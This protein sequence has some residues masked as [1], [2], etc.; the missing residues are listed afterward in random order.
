MRYLAIILCT[1]FSVGAFGQGKTPFG[2]SRAQ[3][4]SITG[5]QIRATAYGI[6]NDTA[7]AIFLPG[8]IVKQISISRFNGSGGITDTT[9]L[10]NRINGKLDSIKISNDTL[11]SYKNGA[12]TFVGIITGGSSTY[13][14]GYGLN[15]AGNRFDVDTSVIPDYRIL[16][17]VINDS[18][19]LLRTYIATN[20]YDKTQVDS[21]SAGKSDTAHGHTF[22]EVTEA[23]NTTTYP[24]TVLDVNFDT[25]P[26]YSAARAAARMYAG[27]DSVKVG[28]CIVKFAVDGGG[29][30]TPSLLANADHRGIRFTSLSYGSGPILT[31]N[32]APT[33]TK[34]LYCSVTPDETWANYG[35][36][37][38][39]RANLGNLQIEM[40]WPKG[41]WAGLMFRDSTNTWRFS[42]NIQ[43]SAVTETG[44]NTIA[45]EETSSGQMG[46]KINAISD[47]QGMVSSG[48]EIIYAGPNGYRVVKSQNYP[49]YLQKQFNIVDAYGNPVPFSALTHLDMFMVNS[50]RSFQMNPQWNYNIWNLFSSSCNLWVT[51]VYEYINMWFLLLGVPFRIRR[52]KRGFKVELIKM[53]RA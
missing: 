35:V 22:Q 36:T 14:D 25:I 24:I 6:I 3:D 34:I 33:A 18:N 49:Y 17:E 32:F 7:I 1:L 47:Y 8:G 37:A 39:A 45:W 16:D 12:G 28:F 29:N 46:G 11:Y 10:S 5:G 41:N 15:L 30:I 31:I 20:Y 51:V 27:S 43:Y 19:D 52:T 2:A 26:G 48:Y 13:T 40:S 50:N 42:P 38:G 23:G 21:L 9:S 44:I 4:T 53:F